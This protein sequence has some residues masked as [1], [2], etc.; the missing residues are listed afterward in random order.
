LWVLSI[1]PLVGDALGDDVDVGWFG[2]SADASAQ[3]AAGLGLL[4]FA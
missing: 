4:A 1:L 2:G 3:S